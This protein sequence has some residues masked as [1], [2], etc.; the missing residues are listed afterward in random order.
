EIARAQRL[1]ARTL[2]DSHTARILIAERS[3]RSQRALRGGAEPG[4]STLPKNAGT[5]A[6]EG[7]MAR[8]NGQHGRSCP[9]LPA[10]LHSSFA[11]KRRIPTPQD[12]PPIATG[13]ASASCE[14]ECALT[15]P[16]FEAPARR[17][18]ATGD[19]D[20]HRC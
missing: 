16:S 9:R 13:R 12:P 4:P 2:G 11:A 6:T 17:R 8:G 14:D 20:H 18:H 5:R 7:A 1:D 10:F 15:K 3:P 19:D